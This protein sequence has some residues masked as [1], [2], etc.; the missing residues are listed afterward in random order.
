MSFRLLAKSYLKQANRRLKNAEEAFREKDYPYAV[1]QSQ[2]CVE[3]SLKA[4]LRMVG[5]DYPKVHDVSPV[6]L[7]VKD[8]FPSWFKGKIDFLAEM[9]RNLA[10]KREPAM[11]GLEVEGLPPE[12]I[13][14]EESA[15]SALN[16]AKSVF[17]SCSKL[18]Q[19]G[20]I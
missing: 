17:E 10:E 14:D 3:L 6:L 12:K 18:I 5:I 20:E 2:E 13:F 11:Y 4:A 15:K 19:S 16:G 7:K 9:S 8:R 1:R